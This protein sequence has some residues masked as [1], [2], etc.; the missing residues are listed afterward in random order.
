MEANRFF[1]YSLKQDVPY[2]S[3][4]VLFPNIKPF[5][6]SVVAVPCLVVPFTLQAAEFSVSA[7]QASQHCCNF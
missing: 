4:L 6:Y 2:S 5:F 3:D 1:A 7:L